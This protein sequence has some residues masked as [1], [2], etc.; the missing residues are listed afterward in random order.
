[1]GTTVV[2]TLGLLGAAAAAVFGQMLPWK[3]AYIGGGLMGLCLLLT[4][5]KMSESGMFAE[6]SSGTVAR[7]DLRMLLARG[8]FGRYVLCILLGVPI[9]FITGILFTFSP[10]L[11][12]G[13]GLTTPLSAGNALLC[14]TLGLAFGDL[15]SGLLS[16]V[17]RSRRKAVGIHL[18]IAFSGMGI[19]LSS[20][21]VS[22]AFIYVLCFIIGTAAGYW[23]VLVTMA[24]EQFGTNLRGT[25]ASSVP[26][27]VRGS[28][29]LVAGSFGLLKASLSALQAALLL[30]VVCFALAFVALWRLNE[31]FGKDLDFYE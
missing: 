12:S 6:A 26:N 18:L 1:L 17:L 14:G 16:Q 9:Y 20:Q 2:A 7:G 10:E 24:A 8:R 11:T 30:G 19:Y 4:R 13:M 23:A 15:C 28:A 22:A 31:T 27:F 5:F 29:A 3:A 25:V 21:G